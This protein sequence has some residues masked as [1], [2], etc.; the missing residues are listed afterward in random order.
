MIDE[1]GMK[2]VGSVSVQAFSRMYVQREETTR[3]LRTTEKNTGKQ[4]RRIGKTKD[5][6]TAPQLSN[7]H[8]C[9]TA[10]NAPLE[11]RAQGHN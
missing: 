11:P 7:G 2:H 9:R 6:T 8:G 5:I 10:D 1:N 3:V 4:A